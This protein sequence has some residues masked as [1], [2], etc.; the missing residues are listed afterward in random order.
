MSTSSSVPSSS[1]STSSSSSDSSPPPA[2]RSRSRR[3]RSGVRGVS[4]SARG[5]R[6]GRV[7]AAR[8]DVGGSA[9]SRDISR[10]GLSNPEG[11]ALGSSGD[12]VEMNQGDVA[13]ARKK[14][15]KLVAQLNDPGHPLGPE[16]FSE[17]M[18]AIISRVPVR[19]V[20]SDSS[21]DT[22]QEQ[23]RSEEATALVVNDAEDDDP[24]PAEERFRE[25]AKRLME[26]RRLAAAAQE[27]QAAHA[28][29]D[30]G[31][32]S[33]ES[34]GSAWSVNAPRA[35]AR[36]SS[37]RSSRRA[38]DGGAGASASPDA[39][40]KAAQAAFADNLL[41]ELASYN[42][43]PTPVVGAPAQPSGPG[44]ASSQLGMLRA[45]EG[46]LGKH[47]WNKG[48]WA[49]F[50]AKGGFL[51]GAAADGILKLAGNSAIQDLGTNAF[52]IP[53]AC[54]FAAFIFGII[55]DAII[56]CRTHKKDAAEKQRELLTNLA[57]RRRE[58]R[59]AEETRAA[60]YAQRFI[61]VQLADVRSHQGL[62]TAHVV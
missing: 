22:T 32:D 54:A 55:A 53:L 40:T 36:S 27:D 44:D 1:L 15:D 45:A 39:D 33:M 21:G 6:E 18:Q 60:E 11:Q 48:E 47:L 14:L 10:R 20:R 9:G 30:D 42:P 62:S 13:R 3:G 57:V 49:F 5:A 38:V 35:G 7:R 4:G 23:T 2:R 12:L 26:A 52:L 31:S 46:L 58:A 25:V 34:S 8:A 17:K 56:S 29:D 28:D 43:P 19:R 37:R 51:L 59:A 50:L 41:K 61:L 16:E 24:V